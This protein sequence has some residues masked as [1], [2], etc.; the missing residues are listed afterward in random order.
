MQHP[1]PGRANY[2]HN[3][4]SAHL[5]ICV[6]NLAQLGGEAAGVPINFLDQPTTHAKRAA[7]QLR[8]EA[9]AQAGHIRQAP[10]GQLIRSGR[11]AGRTTTG[12]MPGLL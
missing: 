4:P 2:S 10:V 1:E 9:E 5:A 7:L 11:A 3:F 8:A 12:T 6:H